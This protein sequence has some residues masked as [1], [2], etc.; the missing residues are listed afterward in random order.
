MTGILEYYYNFFQGMYEYT[1]GEFLK[2][3]VF[4]RRAEKRLDQAGDELE[5]AEFYY[6]MAEVFIR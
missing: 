5:K 3:I 4:Y 6:K 1:Q 2:A